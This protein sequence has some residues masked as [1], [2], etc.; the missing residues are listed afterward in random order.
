M[1]DVMAA[2][3]DHAVPAK[4]RDQWPRALRGQR[5]AQDK[6][7]TII[8]LK[9]HVMCGEQNNALFESGRRYIRCRA[10]WHYAAWREHAAESI[11]L[12][13]SRAKPHPGQLSR[14]TR[15]SCAHWSIA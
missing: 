15:L 13:A 6:A 10:F 2:V 7:F 12:A 1:V 14:T 4:R 9:S 3:T 5:I 11:A 8:S